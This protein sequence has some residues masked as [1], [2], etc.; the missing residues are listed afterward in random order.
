MTTGAIILFGL[1]ILLIIIS[2]ILTIYTKVGEYLLLLILALIFFILGL[3]VQNPPPTNHDVKEGTAHYIEQN[4]I[5][6]VNGDTINTYKTYKI[7][8]IENSK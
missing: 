5:E 6:V 7:E 4:H 3:A 1:A 8:W 2:I